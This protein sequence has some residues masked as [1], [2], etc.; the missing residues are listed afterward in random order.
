MKRMISIFTN[1]KYLK[2][3]KMTP[4]EFVNKTKKP[5]VEAQLHQ[6]AGAIVGD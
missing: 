6:A 3:K 4:E 5:P 1:I 2:I